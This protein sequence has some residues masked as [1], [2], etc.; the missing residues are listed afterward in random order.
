MIRKRDVFYWQE[1][2]ILKNL[3][4]EWKEHIVFKIIDED[5]IEGLGS[6][7][8]YK[9]FGETF[10][11]TMA[12][13]ESLR[14]F[15]ENFD[16]LNELYD[17]QTDL[18]FIIK[19]EHAAKTAVLLAISDYLIKKNSID[20]SK[21]LYTKKDNTYQE[22]LKRVYW[23]KDL[24]IYSLNLDKKNTLKFEFIEKPDLKDIINIKKLFGK[25]DL[26]FDFRGFLN[27]HEFRRVYN[28]LKDL[29]I[30]G[31]EQPVK[32]GSEDNIYDMYE[33][34][35]FWDES[36]EN[37]E[38]IKKLKGQGLVLDI[39]KMGGLL[40]MRKALNISELFGFETVISTRLEHPYNINWS[41]KIKNSFNFVDLNIDNYIVKTSK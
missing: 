15:S 16:D 33:L 7:T 25:Y 13:V 17:F 1:R 35:I 18:E 6:A 3:N 8:P 38:N 31:F 34:P 9:N 37:M 5:G 10:K 27:Y 20:I 4:M 23:K 28:I 29:S 14:R 12:V 11:T 41:K 30:I 2:S 32:P 19:K 40:N 22:T 39:T 21:I 26:W 36:I 24:N